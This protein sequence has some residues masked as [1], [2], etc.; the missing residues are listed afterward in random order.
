MTARQRQDR[1][2]AAGQEI[3]PGGAL[4]RALVLDGRDE[5]GL[6]V[7]PAAAPDPRAARRAA[8]PAVAADEETARELRPGR[9]RDGDALRAHLLRLDGGA[10]DEPYAR[11]GFECREEGRIEE[12]VLEQV[13]HRTLLDLGMVEGQHEGRGPPA[14]VP[15]AVTTR[16]I[17]WACDASPSQ[18]PSA[19][20]SRFEASASA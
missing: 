8:L 6:S 20:S 17:G 11:L 14:V 3:L 9:E 19:A 16:R 4:V 2:R 5:G 7:A 13:A 12:A 18:R 15:S 1:E 10:R